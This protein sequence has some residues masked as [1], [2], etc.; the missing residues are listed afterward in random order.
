MDCLAPWRSQRDASG[1]SDNAYS[2]GSGAADDGAVC[3]GR[4]FNWALLSRT[5]RSACCAQAPSTLAAGAAAIVEDE[6]ENES[7]LESEDQGGPERPGGRRTL[8]DDKVVNPSGPKNWEWTPKLEAAFKFKCGCEQL[9]MKKGGAAAGA[10]GAHC[11]AAQCARRAITCAESWSGTSTGPPAA[12][13]TALQS[14]VWLGCCATA[15]GML[16]GI[17]E[18]TFLRARADARKIGRRKPAAKPVRMA[19]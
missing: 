9:C 5:G 7:E 4:N 8:W 18:S 13:A 1:G 6:S 16:V 12:L 15:F 14:W 19:V 2:D 10:G 17:S 11:D 3:L